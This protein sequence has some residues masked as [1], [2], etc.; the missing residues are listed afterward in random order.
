MT[1]KRGPVEW[2]DPGQPDLNVALVRDLLA[3]QFPAWK[4]LPLRPAE[5]DGH[6][7]RTFR[8]GSDM[9]VRLPSREAYA[10]QVAK[11]QTWLP[12]LR[13]HLPLSIPI[14]LAMGAPGEGYP[15]PW[16][17]YRWIDGETANTARIDD[18]VRF[19]NV[20]ADFLDALHRVD[21][22]DGPP[23]GP[24]SFFRGSPLEVYD[25]ETRDAIDSLRGDVDEA[26]ATAVWQSAIASPCGS[27]PVWVHGDFA[28]TNLL[29]R[30]GRLDAV[31]DF[32]CCAVGDPACDLVI[33][34]T[35]LSGEA[36]EAF[37]RALPLDPGTWAR[38]RG[39]ALWK[40]LITLADRRP[41]TAT[42][43]SDARRTLAAVIGDFEQHA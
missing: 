21:A 19:A 42:P 28:A 31:I 17:V 12:R 3:T 25:S 23:A 4:D 39:W 27:P 6:D 26:L 10:A 11:E 15:W 34:W 32:G 41:A 43:W 13:P 8:L 33:A 36:R 29:V 37:R 9:S 38:A 24:H 30:D 35:L 20:L 14:P 18:P 5:S 1:W 7:N 2:L 22:R 16:S 40:A